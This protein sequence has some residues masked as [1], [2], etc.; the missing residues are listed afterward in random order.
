MG[1]FDEY[2]SFFDQYQRQ[3]GGK[4]TVF[5]Q[6]GIFYEVYGIENEHE[7]LGHASEIAS[8]LNV[9]LTRVDKSIVENN[10]HNPLMMGFPCASAD[11]NIQILIDHGYTVVIV[12]QT[13]EKQ[14]GS[15]KIFIR[16]VTSVHSPATYA[17]TSKTE[18]FLVSIYI[19][20][21]LK[22]GKYLY[23]IGLT[24]VDLGTGK[25]YAHQ[26]ISR[27]ND[28]N[29]SLDEM[30]RFVQTFQPTEI[31]VAQNYNEKEK[32]HDILK[33][34][35]ADRDNITIHH[36]DVKSNPK[37]LSNGF[38][39][40][41]LKTFYH[42]GIL[43]PVQYL[44]LEFKASVV[45][46]FCI[47]LEF[48]TD[49]NRYLLK[50]LGRPEL[51]N[52]NNTLIL[53]NNSINQLNLIPSRGCSKRTDSV[54]GIITE[55]STNMGKRL[56]KSRLLNPLIDT[57]EIN[58]RYDY[59]DAMLE[60]HIDLTQLIASNTLTKWYLTVEKHLREIADLERLHRKIE[61]GTLQPLE[62]SL[63]A[64]T[65]NVVKNLLDAIA[66]H[67]LFAKLFPD[68]AREQTTSFINFYTTAIDVVEA[69]KHDIK[70][71]SANFFKPGYNSELDSNDNI[72]R[73]NKR[74]LDELALQLSK[75]SKSTADDHVVVKSSEDGFYLH[76]SKSRYKAIETAFK[77][78][79]LS[80][81]TKINSIREF[82]VD[83]RTKTSTKLKGYIISDANDLIA[84]ATKQLKTK[85]VAAYGLF[86]AD[87]TEKYGAFFT[88]ITNGIAEL[89]V[90]KSSAKCALKNKYVRPTVVGSEGDR[91]SFDIINMR[92]PIIEKLDEQ[93]SYV[94]HSF[95]LSSQG[96]LL[97][98]IN[99]AGKSSTM[100]AAGIAV[101][102]AQ[103]GFYVPADEFVL[104]PFTTLMTRIL[105]ND[106]I[107]KG[108]SSYAVEMTELRGILNRVNCNT[109]VLGDEICH[110]TE[111]YSGISLVAAS[112]IYLSQIGATFIFATHL[113]QLS[114]MEEI[115]ALTNLRQC[116]LTVHYDKV[117]DEL[118]YDRKI[119]DGSG[120]VM[121]GIEVAKAMQVP[122][123]I[124]S[125][126]MAI[127]KKY[128]TAPA[129]CTASVYNP[130][131]YIDKCKI[132]DLP[133]KEVH[134]IK[135]QSESDDKGFIDSTHKNHKSNLVALCD[136]HHRMVHCP[137]NTE[138]II[139]GYHSDGSLE[140]KLRKPL[141]SFRVKPI[142]I[143]S[144]LP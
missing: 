37:I 3:Y 65:Y 32:P 108:L 119:K 66:S 104:T 141:R 27:E 112:L 15:K 2:I 59:V 110:G 7:K 143:R 44:D 136:L 22:K 134:H 42:T 61:T 80:D 140:Y 92:H 26:S 113:Q 129:V 124:I 84:S 126:A 39:N 14:V 132:C 81:G 128:Y 86:L 17:S 33:I 71:V 18:N 63:V 67:T 100:K 99:A 1:R 72:I 50:K 121:Y 116:H 13:A 74:L 62:F 94:P 87:V 28:T 77:P 58:K 120:D 111:T 96:M 43:S 38:H 127:R 133:A 11:R 30:Y 34:L 117:T 29:G 144:S 115:T 114:N 35:D 9:Q 45:V 83:D 64:S 76:I 48:C 75:L 20:S 25:I 106:N 125:T 16:E 103:A 93:T 53:D 41:Y 36:Y 51:W 40:H 46:S 135:F 5:Y 107:F 56:L 131:V 91:A 49:H 89:D 60:D 122:S 130:E 137:K 109:L 138:L 142:I 101:T 21:N 52:N 73:T 102:L 118:I 47:M 55:T 105:G 79:T 8:I 31:I 123:H 70:G 97:Y 90:Y 98:G 68:T 95:R 69:S 78:F 82:A 85:I 23:D 19:E 88:S 139:I 54:L 10:R 4:T 12:D 6:C 57:V 24:A